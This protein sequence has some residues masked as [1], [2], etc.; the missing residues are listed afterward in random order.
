M[1]QVPEINVKWILPI[2]FDLFQ[3]E[4]ENMAKISKRGYKNCPSFMFCCKIY[5]IFKER[6]LT[7]ITGWRS[8]TGSA[9]CDL[10]AVMKVSGVSQ[11]KLSFC[12]KDA[13]EWPT[14]RD[15]R[16]QQAQYTPY[17]RF[18]STLNGRQTLSF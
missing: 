13:P 4:K 2:L 15:W 1:L 5:F 16:L 8:F 6:F 17:L 11:P 14:E 3:H 10:S 18:F 7:L 9:T 12:T